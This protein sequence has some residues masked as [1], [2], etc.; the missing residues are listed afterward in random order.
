MAKINVQA[1]I[2]ISITVLIAAGAVACIVY[3][4]TEANSRGYKFVAGGSVV[5]MHIVWL[6]IWALANEFC[7]G[8]WDRHESIWRGF[9]IV[10]GVLYLLFIVGGLIYGAVQHDT[11]V[12]GAI[13]TAAVTAI[14]CC[15]IW[16]AILLAVICIVLSQP[17]EGCHRG[18]HDLDHPH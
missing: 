5:L 14:V 11:C 15:L 18:A 3:G 10:F 13:L 16:A 1:T 2:V 9:A 12:G 8:F 17:C 4:A 7:R 6:W